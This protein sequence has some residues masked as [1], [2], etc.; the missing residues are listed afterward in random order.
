MEAESKGAQTMGKKMRFGIAALIAAGT[1]ALAPAAFAGS[2]NSVSPLRGGGDEIRKSGTCSMG[3][4]WTLN[5]KADNGQIEVEFEVDQNVVG[6]TWKVV[7]KDNGTV[8]FKGKKVTKAPSGSFTVRKL[9]TDQPG[10]DNLTA[11]ARNLSTD[12]LCKASLG[13]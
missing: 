3:S 6:Q 5:A 7:M 2:H 12:E 11:K 10:T 1:L 13:F 9:I 4:I 8:F